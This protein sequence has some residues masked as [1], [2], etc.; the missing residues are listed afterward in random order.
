MQF[1]LLLSICLAT[2]SLALAYPQNIDSKSRIEAR[3]AAP[4]PF[5]SVSFRLIY[6]ILSRSY[7]I[8]TNCSFLVIRALVMIEVLLNALEDIYAATRPVTV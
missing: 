3:E 5:F 1:Q 4:I 2:A 7:L 6:L 8:V